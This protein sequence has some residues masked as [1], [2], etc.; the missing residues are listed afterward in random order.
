[1]GLEETNSSGSQSLSDLEFSDGVFRGAGVSEH[2]FDCV[3]GRA[4]TS[5]RSERAF[6]KHRTRAGLA[7]S[8]TT[9]PTR[10]RFQGLRNRSFR[11]A[12]ARE[13]RRSQ[14]TTAFAGNPSAARCA[15]HSSG[16]RVSAMTAL[17]VSSGG[18]RPSRIAATM[19]GARPVK[20]RSRP[21]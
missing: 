12:V 9:Q 13:Q 5:T 10:G 7:S 14:G 2:H 4:V 3:V 1:M 11:C 15:D 21:A 20:R 6:L 16:S 8:G 17:A 19:S 18:C